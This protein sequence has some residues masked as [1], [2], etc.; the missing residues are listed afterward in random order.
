[1]ESVSQYHTTTT[2]GRARLQTAIST[3]RDSSCST[4]DALGGVERSL[5]HTRLQT[6]ISSLSQQLLSLVWT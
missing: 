2:V 6:A 4:A 5:G 1:M 3:L